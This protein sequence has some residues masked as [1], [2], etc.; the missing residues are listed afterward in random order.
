M[1]TGIKFQSSDTFVTQTVGRLLT[2]VFLW[3]LTLLSL[4]YRYDE[5]CEFMNRWP[6]QSTCY[7]SIPSYDHV[8]ESCS[9]I[10]FAVLWGTLNYLFSLR[11]KILHSTNE[12]YLTSVARIPN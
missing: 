8:A 7:K 10:N 3:V 4:L 6:L 9:I 2:A 1:E 5:M 11:N 12:S